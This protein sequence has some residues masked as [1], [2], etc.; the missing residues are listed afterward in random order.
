[1]K[2]SKKKLKSGYM[3]PAAMAMVAVMVI[4]TSSLLSN[5]DFAI[6]SE[7]K[8]DNRVRAN[9]LARTGLEN[10]TFLLRNLASQ[11]ENMSMLC[12]FLPRVGGVG[13]CD[14]DS[15]TLTPAIASYS[16]E[17]FSDW[18]QLDQD[19]DFDNLNDDENDANACGISGSYTGKDSWP[20]D[21][22]R[23]LATTFF[24]PGSDD[25]GGGNIARSQALLQ[26]INLGFIPDDQLDPGNGGFTLEAWTYLTDDNYLGD[27]HWPRIFDLGNP[28][29]TNNQGNSN[30]LLA[31]QSDS[32]N[33]VSHYF[34]PTGNGLC[35]CPNDNNNKARIDGSNGIPFPA[36]IWVHS[37]L[38]VERN[39]MRM[40]MTCNNDSMARGV[41][42]TWLASDGPN[43]SANARTSLP[44]QC[45]NGN[46]IVR[47]FANP[48]DAEG[49]SIVPTALDTNGWTT[50]TENPT[51]PN[52]AVPY[53]SNFLGRSNW[54]QD[55]FTQGYFHNAR[56]W[57]R[58][59]TED[60]IQE[61]IENDLDGIP[62]T[63][64]TPGGSSAILSNQF[65]KRSTR[66]S[67]RYDHGSHFLRYFT[68]MD[69]DNP[70][71]IANS[72]FPYTFRV[73]SCAWSKSD[74]AKSVATFSS[75]LR[76]GVTD[77]GRGIITN[78]K[79]Y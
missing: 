45:N 67:P 15:N 69:N 78:V 63:T 42:D 22:I 10:I 66:M 37:F 56:I 1:M 23:N 47:E 4:I 26:S 18:I 43:T 36:R 5:S 13:D 21:L 34:Q 46:T 35:N 29:P 64:V 7:Y 41:N 62:L 59:L 28:T 55:S 19:T 27:A 8:E 60:E 76:Y 58:A 72:S 57:Q 17:P 3:L 30:I 31:W 52:N 75:T 74:Q 77:D 79:R 12:A 40:G 33:L 70:N 61:N 68:V 38:T 51:R 32:G 73:M 2:T 39:M 9:A 11:S 20:A 16:S 54:E 71:N 14:S 24:I 50:W 6:Q 49:K 53:T 44:S 25:P 48:T 65:L